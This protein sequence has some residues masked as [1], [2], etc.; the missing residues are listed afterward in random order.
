MN[1]SRAL[2][3]LFMIAGVFASFV[4]GQSPTDPDSAAMKNVQAAIS[5]AAQPGPEHERLASLAGEWQQE[6]KVWMEPG[7]EPVILPGVCINKMILG[8]R[9]LQLTAESEFM[10]E[11]TE[12]INIIGFDRRHKAYTLVGFDTW[13]TY[14]V[15][16]S[17]SYDDSTKTITMSGE[18]YDPIAGITQKY[19]MTLQFMDENKFVMAVILKEE[20]QTKVGDSFQLA[21]ITFT[22][23]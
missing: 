16:A 12:S 7:S 2:L 20:T 9:F 23:Q 3:S 17:G 1:Y 18:D 14:Y 21:K 19:D 15:T 22:R 4:A 11:K 13:G 10:G 6:V 8:G 5:A